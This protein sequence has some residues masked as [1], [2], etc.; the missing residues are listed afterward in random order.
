M[1][2]CH[3]DKGEQIV[4]LTVMFQTKYLAVFHKLE[5]KHLEHLCITSLYAYLIFLNYLLISQNNDIEIKDT[6]ILKV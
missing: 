6:S 2:S 1:C 3:A 4:C 5:S